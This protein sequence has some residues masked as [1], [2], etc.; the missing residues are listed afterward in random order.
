MFTDKCRNI[1]Q[2]G[3]LPNTGSPITT[4]GDDK[5]VSGNAKSFGGLKGIV[6]GDNEWCSSP[7]YRFF[8]VLPAAPFYKNQD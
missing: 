2:A 1:L 5:E 4:L 3:A 6:R 7:L 8:G